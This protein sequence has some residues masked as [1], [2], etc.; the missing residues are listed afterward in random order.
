MKKYYIHNGKEQEGPLDLEDLKTKL[1]K[2]DTPIWHDGLTNW[3]TAD[4]VEEIK[5][6]I[7]NATPPQFL[8]NN[9]SH[10]NDNNDLSEIRKNNISANEPKKKKTKKIIIVFLLFLSVIIGGLFIFENIKKEHNNEASVDTYKEKEMT[11]E[12][13]EHSTPTNF[14]IAEAN[15]NKNFFGNKLKI[16]GIITNNAT[17]ATYK[18]V[19]I[20]VTYFSKTETELGSVDQILY[21]KFPPNSKTNFELKIEN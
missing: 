5:D 19:V 18:D 11:I 2:K 9:Q 14:L 21:E 1:I 17:I 13:I 6:F 8:M 7:R 20:R 16:R 3:T 15:Y 4:K 10:L 12:E